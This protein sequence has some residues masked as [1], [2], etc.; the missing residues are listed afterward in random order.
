MKRSF[1]VIEAYESQNVSDMTGKQ[2]ASVKIN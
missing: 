2:A 1:L